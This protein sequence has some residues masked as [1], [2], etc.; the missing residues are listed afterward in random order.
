MGPIII[1]IHPGLSLVCVV[2][3]AGLLEWMHS[4]A[5]AASFVTRIVSSS[6]I[7]ASG[8]VLL[9]WA[10]RTLKRENT[11][12]E[13]H[14]VPS[15]FVTSGPFRF[16]RNPM[17][18]A[19]ILLV[20]AFVFLTGSLW[21]LVSAMIQFTLLHTWVIPAEEERLKRAFPEETQAWFSTTR[22][23]L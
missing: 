11:S 2:G 9:F 20:L 6:I 10:I 22:R 8:T 12:I 4:L 15:S 14:D 23:W 21:F 1:R 5:T 16:S 7:F 19:N 18:F 3:L 13:P 17:Y